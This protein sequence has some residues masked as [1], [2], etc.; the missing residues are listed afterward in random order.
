M[1]PFKSRTQGQTEQWRAHGIGSKRI[2]GQG[3]AHKTACKHIF[4]T[5]CLS[6]FIVATRLTQFTARKSSHKTMA[7]QQTETQAV[8][9]EILSGQKK[10][11]LLLNC[12]HNA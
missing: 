12:S 10:K 3:N 9:R 5:I 4:G 1:L 6:W 8:K 2:H 7:S 11:A